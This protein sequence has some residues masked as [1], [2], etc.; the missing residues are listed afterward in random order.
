MKIIANS[1]P[2]CAYNQLYFS[3]WW[4]VMQWLTLS[5][6][7]QPR[8]R[9][10]HGSGPCVMWQINRNQSGCVCVCDHRRSDNVRPWSLWENKA[11]TLHVLTVLIL[12]AHTQT[13]QLTSYCFCFFFILSAATASTPR[14][15]VHELF[16]T[17][18]L[19]ELN[20]DSLVY[21]WHSWNPNDEKCLRINET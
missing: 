1:S 19:N 4:T 10:P 14:F 8:F 16:Q 9:G 13:Y 15:I 11:Q 12:A 5:A 2:K 20:M 17:C 7:F 6:V 3:L 21:W 18:S